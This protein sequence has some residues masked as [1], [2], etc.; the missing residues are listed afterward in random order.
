MIKISIL[1]PNNE[2]AR[3]DMRYYTDTHMPMSIALLG[4]HSGYR[5]VTVERG[6]EGAL[7]G[8]DVAYVAM[9]HFL[10][11]SVADFAAAF[12]PHAE[13]LQGD[14]PKYTDI[15]PIIQVSE[16]LISRMS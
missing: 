2:A 13:A 10:F 3:F 8:T 14:I 15:K 1:Y 16:V 9:C 6:L 11:D 7:P 4:A 5:G 12:A